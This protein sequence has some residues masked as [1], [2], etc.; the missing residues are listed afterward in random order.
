MKQD[1]IREMFNS[2]AKE[3]GEKTNEMQDLILGE[4]N[5]DG[6][7]M[8]I[9]EFTSAKEEAQHKNLLDHERK[10]IEPLLEAIGYSYEQVYTTH[11][12]KGSKKRRIFYIYA[13]PKKRNCID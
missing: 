4:G 11:C 8:I 13:L 10:K 12:F 3:L 9:A 5:T 7:I 2:C 6:D 1:K